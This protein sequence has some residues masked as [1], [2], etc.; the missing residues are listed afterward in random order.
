MQSRSLNCTFT[1]QEPWYKSKL[2]LLRRSGQNLG[3][4]GIRTEKLF[5]P[6][7]QMWKFCE[8]WG[9]FSENTGFG[10]Y[11]FFSPSFKNA[12]SVKWNIFSRINLQM[13]PQYLKRTIHS[14]IS[15]CLN[16]IYISRQ[17]LSMLLQHHTRGEVGE[18]V[19][20]QTENPKAHSS[21]EKT[22]YIRINTSE[23]AWIFLQGFSDQRKELL[24]SSPA[25]EDET[26]TASLKSYSC[27]CAWIQGTG[28]KTNITKRLNR[29]RVHPGM[30]NDLKNQCREDF[31]RLV[32]FQLIV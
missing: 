2:L 3:Q 21:G 24:L 29:S 10:D 28:R 5:S 22:H 12:D 9:S 25:P 11:F 30:N 8:F 26:W 15:K 7:K 20:T 31:D 4:K 32:T 6:G 19:Q 13:E 27:Y 14:W 17:A 1:K 16:L 18:E 23:T